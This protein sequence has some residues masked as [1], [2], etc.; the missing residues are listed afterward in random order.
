MDRIA[1]L[2]SASSRPSNGGSSSQAPPGQNANSAATDKKLDLHRSVREQ[3]NNIRAHI[4]DLHNISTTG[5]ERKAASDYCWA[6]IVKLAG[7]VNAAAAAGLPPHDQKVFGDGISAAEKKLKETC[8]AFAAQEKFR[9]SNGTR[10][11]GSAGRESF[12]K[13]SKNESALSVNECSG[14]NVEEKDAFASAASGASTYTTDFSYRPHNQHGSRHEYRPIPDDSIS[15]ENE[16]N[17]HILLPATETHKAHRGDFSLL[18]RC[19]VD[20]TPTSETPGTGWPL[21][22]LTLKN[23]RSSLLICGSITG[24]VHLTRLQHCI[25]VVAAGQLRMHDS[26]D[27]DVYLRCGSRPII[28]NCFN[29]RFASLPHYHERLVPQNIFLSQDTNGL[30]R[31]VQDFGWVNAERP[32]PNWSMV[33]DKAILGDEIWSKVVKGS[34]T[35]GLDEILDAVGLGTR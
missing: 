17:M 29:I 15:L 23:I 11:S 13:A 21:V 35:V 33:P 20:R 9:F 28:E 12:F 5:G 25:I 18:T 31:Q 27:C 8:K 34:P 30:W 22:S 10:G 16:D 14:S 6:L 19:V 2:D 1:N 32:S 4:D 24:A 7:E 3:L 26:R